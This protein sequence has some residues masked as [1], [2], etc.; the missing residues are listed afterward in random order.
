MHNPGQ[1]S[2]GVEPARAYIKAIESIDSMEAMTNYL[3]NADGMNFSQDQWVGITV[4]AG[5]NDRE[6]NT[7]MLAAKPV[8]TLQDQDAYSEMTN[9]ALGLKEY[10]NEK[11]SYLLT[12]RGY[13]DSAIQGILPRCY[14]FEGRLAEVME[15]T[16][17]QNSID[18]LQSADNTYTIEQIEG[19]QGAYPLTAL[20]AHYKMEGSNHYTVCEPDYVTDLGK[21]YTQGNLEE[22]K[23]YYLVRTLNE[24]MPIL[25]REAFDKYTEIKLAM[26]GSS[27]TKDG[28]KNPDGDAKDNKKTEETAILLDNFIGTY[29]AEPMDEIYVTQYCDAGQK[30]EIQEM[31]KEIISYYRV[32]LQDEDWLSEET[33]NEAVAKLDNLAVRAVYPDTFTDYSELS[34]K[35]G[36]NLVEAVSAIDDFKR[37]IMAPKV[38]T[39]VNRNEWNLSTMSTTE[40]NAYYNPQENAINILPGIL[41]NGT[42]YRSDMSQEDKLARLGSIIGHEIT[43]AFDITGSEFDKDGRVSGW[44]T[45]EDNTAFQ[46]RTM[47]MSKYYNVLTHYPGATGYTGNVTSEAIADMGRMKC[48]LALAAEDPGFDY[49]QFFTSYAALWRQK[50]TEDV[51]Q[52]LAQGD[53]HPLAFL[54]T[55]VTIQQFDAFSKA[56]GVEP[57]DVMY[58]EEWDRI[59]VWLEWMKKEEQPWEKP[60]FP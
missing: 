32:M 51:E 39:A 18:Y 56:F 13:D 25:D 58:I 3:L 10:N 26:E 38:N 52:S 23:S 55:N 59:L 54:R 40:V 20:L 33:R 27:K 7:V 42:F 44:W 57:G 34:F 21:P 22:M 36:G 53:E 6:N 12:R 35:S 29:L 19:I 50:A 45:L 16:D 4:E 28:D 31:I 47:K 48:M 43:H 11:I 46:E 60:L 41:A 14:Q 8:L 24:V 2:Q 15:P 9:G 30:A 17:D 5:L 37:G 1:P 49:K